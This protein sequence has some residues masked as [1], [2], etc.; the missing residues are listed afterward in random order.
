MKKDI[1][2][3]WMQWSWKWTQWKLLV[4]KYWYKM[5]ETWAE[6]RKLT[7]NGSDLWRK[8]KEIIDAGN[9]VDAKI[10][11]EVIENYLNNISSEDRVIFDWIPR[12]IEQ[13]ELF[14]KIMKK[15]W[16]EPLWINIKITRKEAL[17]RLTIRF[18]CLWVDTTNNPLITEQE[19]IAQWWKVVKRNDDN[20]ESINKRLEA[21]ENE[22]QP[23][24]NK[25]ISENRM[26]EINWIQGVEEVSRELVSSFEA[27]VL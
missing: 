7:E 20:E 26:L 25:Y 12:S 2:M 23:V 15:F 5:F 17:Q 6:L 19:C 1:M 22:T 3:F 4:Q 27:W 11:M 9:L 10:V 24:I 18:I 21:F 16:R 14:E 8:I 13:Q